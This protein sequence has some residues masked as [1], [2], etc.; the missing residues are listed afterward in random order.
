M[1]K[2]VMTLVKKITT[3]KVV[4][5]VVPK[6]ATKKTSVKSTPKK[7]DLVLTGNS[8]SFW[9]SDGQILNSLVALQAALSEMNIEVFSHHVTKEKH[10]FA[11]WV[12]VVLCD[13]LCAED[14]RKSKTPAVAEKIVTKHLKSYKI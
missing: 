13:D 9:V 1:Q 10:D 2:K 3:K 4:K 14:L 12:E 7:K 11:N 8:T 5:K 6:K